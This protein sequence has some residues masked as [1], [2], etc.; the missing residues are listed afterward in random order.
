MDTQIQPKLLKCLRISGSADWRGPDRQ[1]DIRLIAASHQDLNALVE[2]K[3]FRS[4]LY[5]R[6]STIPVVCPPLRER[7]EDIPQLASIS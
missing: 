4:D 7:V 3:K 1:V 2:Q 5:F 6:I